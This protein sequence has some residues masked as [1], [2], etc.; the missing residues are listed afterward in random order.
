[1]NPQAVPTDEES[2]EAA[3]RDADQ[4]AGAGG[5]SESAQPCK[6]LPAN[7]LVIVIDG[8]TKKK[9]AGV[10]VQIQG[11]AKLSKPSSAKGRAEFM[12]IPP[13]SYSITHN[14]ACLKPASASATAVAGQTA[15]ATLT[16][17]HTHC[18][19]EIK[20]LTFKGNNPVEN[21]TTGNFTAPEWRAGRAD[22]D[23]RPVA[24][25]RNQKI[26]MDAKFKVV[27]EPCRKE[28][29]AIEGT[30]SFGK[31]LKWAGSVDVAPGAAEVS[32]T[33]LTSDDV[34][35]D[36]IA[37]FE[38][39]NI[40][41]R[42]K[43][44]GSDWHA[45]GSTLNVLYVTLGNP[46][47][48]PNYWT[49]IDL[50]CRSAGGIAKEP[51]FVKAVIAPFQAALGDGNGI[52]RKRDGVQLTYYKMAAGTPSQ[53]VYTTQALL[54]RGDGTGRCGAWAKLL[55]DTHK[56]HGVTSSKV[57]GV[58][59][60][61]SE[62][63]YLLVENCVFA[64]AGSLSVPFPYEGNV[65]CTKG[66]GIPGQGKTNPQ[67]I[68]GDHALVRYGTDIYDPSYGS[69][70]VSDLKTWEDSGIAGLGSG[71]LVWFKQAGC[72]QAISEQCS[73]GFTVYVAV[74]GDTLASIAA[75]FG[76]SSGAALYNHPY[77]QHLHSAVG[78]FV[79][80]VID[81]ILGTPGAHAPAEAI[82]AG[83]KIYIPREISNVRILKE[84][85]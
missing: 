10:T 44:D 63:A 47:G 64:G 37:L 9:Q 69:G 62:A 52:K 83:D 4:N 48:T 8:E 6:K 43:P 3:S 80:G 68:F 39:K 77:N 66:N 55:V 78:E 13:G 74:A 28:Q 16:V 56:V 11:P 1:M 26:G 84:R 23:Q 29:V 36:E 22:T 51:D 67:F 21:D 57:L 81:S 24:Y 50:S 45:A 35:P 42:A 20:E 32:A 17:F 27:T 25:A 46:S 2:L 76:V 75:K 79:G 59:P 30:G 5:D 34:L 54:S 33:G 71:G 49:L 18:V 12:G 14:D 85:P 58:V 7:L 61:S 60:D 41:W 53:G 65:E 40:Q 31:N 72:N 73:D 70:P 82:S 38:T 15:K 19:L